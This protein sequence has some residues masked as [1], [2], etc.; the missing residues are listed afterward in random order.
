[1]VCAVIV[2]KVIGCALPI[3]A[4]LLHLDPALMAGPMITTIV[5]ALTLLIYFGFATLFISFLYSIGI[6]LCVVDSE[7][8]NSGDGQENTKVMLP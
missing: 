3:L 4:K 8:Y 1:M 2:A 7:N 5:D 6:N